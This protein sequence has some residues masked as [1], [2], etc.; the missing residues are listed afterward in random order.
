[1]SNN[2]FIEDVINGPIMK[3]V[4]PKVVIPPKAPNMNNTV[5]VFAICLVINGL[6][7]SSVKNMISEN[8]NVAI[9]VE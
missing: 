8:T 3:P 4:N 9:N 5:F 6:T 1:M 2:T 7:K